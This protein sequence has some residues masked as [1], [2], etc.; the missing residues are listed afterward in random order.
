MWGTKHIT[1]YK[2]MAKVQKTTDAQ[3][4]VWAKR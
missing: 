4:N 1:T 2:L 3:K